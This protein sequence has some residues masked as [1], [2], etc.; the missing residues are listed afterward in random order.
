MKD[1]IAEEDSVPAD[2]LFLSDKDLSVIKRYGLLNPDGAG[3]GRYQV[4]HP[5]TYV[6]DREGI[7]R[8]MFVEVDY[9]IRPSN[10]DVLAALAQLH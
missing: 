1:R 4:P 8:W 2:F 6:I 9:S 3:S 10:E 7:V 5:A